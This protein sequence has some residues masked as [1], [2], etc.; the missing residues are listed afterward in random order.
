MRITDYFKV[1][2]KK[3]EVNESIASILEKKSK[4][5]SQLESCYSR[6]ESIELCNSNSK[7]A[8]AFILSNFLIVDIVNLALL[9]FNKTTIGNSDSWKEKINAIPE[10]EL[11]SQFKKHA[12]VEEAKYET[13]EDK[14]ESLELSLSALLGAVEKHIFKKNKSQF[15]NPVD[16]F[17]TKSKFQIVAGVILLILCIVVGRKQYKIWKP[18]KNDVA[19]IYYFNEQYKTP[20][21]SNSISADVKPSKEWAEVSFVLPEPSN[22]NDIKIEPVHQIYA[23]IQVRDVKYYDA[24]KKII[25]EQTFKINK[26]GIIDNLEKNEV[27]CAEA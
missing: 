25:Y 3:P 21:T 11:V 23:R 6:L 7:P 18:I 13:E 12:S 17:K 24:N 2:F 8:D 4:L 1:S 15:E 27:C 19:K 9:F 22:I 5:K 20:T 26:T 16:D 10:E 14:C